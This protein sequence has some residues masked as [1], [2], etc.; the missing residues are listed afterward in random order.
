MTEY[1]QV[2]TTTH[3]QDEAQRIAQ[4]LVAR[5]LAACVQVLGPITSTYWWQGKIESDEEW[6][7][8]AK[9]KKQ[10]YDQVERAIRDLHSYEVPEILAVPIAAGNPAYLAWLGR[11]LRAHDAE[12][13]PA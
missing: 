3:R 9:S 6:L 2:Y 12:N 5:K 8:V 7:C 1:I 13:P 4:D 10:L 11:E